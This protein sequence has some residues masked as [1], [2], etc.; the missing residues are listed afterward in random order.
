MWVEK[1]VMTIYATMPKEQVVPLIATTIAVSLIK[2]AA[3][4]GGILLIKW[5]K[6]LKTQFYLYFQTVL[7]QASLD[8]NRHLPFGKC[9]KNNSYLRLSVQSA[10]KSST[11]AV[12]RHSTVSDAP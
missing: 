5:F 1:D 8:I 12:A 6:L 10:I 3:I 11:L 2:V 9:H 7:K 4:T